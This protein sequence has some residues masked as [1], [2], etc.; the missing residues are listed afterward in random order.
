M[1]SVTIAAVIAAGT[2]AAMTAHA[3]NPAFSSHDHLVLHSLPSAAATAVSLP[4]VSVDAGDT[5]AII[6]D[7][8]ESGA[9]AD[10]VRVVLT[11]TD[12]LA[13]VEPGFRSVIPTDQEMHDDS[14][15]VRVPDMPEASDRIF[16]VKLFRLGKVPLQVCDAGLIRIEGDRKS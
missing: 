3:A 11:L 1:R 7:C 8:V 12:A 15:L 10:S 5:F 2:A 14:L 6:G 13:S 4:T 9:S 16:A